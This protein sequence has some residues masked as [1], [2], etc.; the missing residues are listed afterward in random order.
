M[1]LHELSEKDVVQTK[2]G[3][4]LG[5]VD[6]VVFDPET[7]QLRSVILH[8]RSHLFGLLGRDEDLVLPWESLKN[9]GVDVIMVDAEPCPVQHRGQRHQ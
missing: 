9:I 7:A 1:T 2:T 6:D 5:R 8:G 4:N 3:E